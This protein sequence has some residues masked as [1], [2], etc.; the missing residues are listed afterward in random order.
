MIP[1][2]KFNRLGAVSFTFLLVTARPSHDVH[3]QEMTGT[4][5]Q[6]GSVTKADA[7]SPRI[8][9]K[10]ANAALTKFPVRIPRQGPVTLHIQL[11]LDRAHFSPGIIDG[12]WG[13]N[14]AKALAFFANPEGAGGGDTPPLISSLDKATY[15][16]LREAAGPAPLLDRYA[17]TEQDLQGPFVSIPDTVYAQ[18]ELT[19]L[20]YSSAIEAIAEKFHTSEAL[21]A[22]LNP[23]VK[24]N[25]LAGG[26][27]LV[28]PNIPDPTAASP[29]DTMIVARLIISKQG[30]WTHAVNAA[31]RIL[32]HFPSTLGAGYDPSPT[33][34]FRVTG[35]A[36]DPAFHYQPRLFAEV[37]DTKTEAHLPP[38]PNSPVG[39]VWMAL[40]KP[41]YGIHGTASPQTI[42]YAN[43]HGCVRLTNWDALQLSDIVDSGTPVQFK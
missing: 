23:R 30:Y 3:S 26:T 38:G 5:Q 12:A 15:G 16:R 14:A 39:V 32:Y 20:C 24:L 27:Q 11:L 10:S 2:R 21:L 31:G 34:D 29:M 13:I 42:G 40:S 35:I 43:S 1:S 28:V 6:P 36:R 37:P 19:C 22:Q 25:N 33:G 18:A 9:E 4:G 7:R 17:I 8:T 41:H